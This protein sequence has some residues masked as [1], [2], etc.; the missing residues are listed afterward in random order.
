MRNIHRNI[1]VDYVDLSGSQSSQDSFEN[2]EN[3]GIH[4]T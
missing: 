2:G 1:K 4:M 3:W